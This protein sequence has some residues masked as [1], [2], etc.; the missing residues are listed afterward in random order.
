MDRIESRS[1]SKPMRGPLVNWVRVNGRRSDG[2]GHVP[3][4]NVM[5]VVTDVI[6]AEQECPETSCDEILRIM[7]SD[8]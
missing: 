6:V 5:D 2:A 3:W 1:K 4:H 7:R 8:R